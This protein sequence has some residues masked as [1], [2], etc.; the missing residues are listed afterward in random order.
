MQQV[1]FELCR[2]MVKQLDIKDAH[3]DKRTIGGVEGAIAKGTIEGRQ[4]T[5]II[6]PANGQATT[7]VIMATP[8]RQNWADHLVESIRKS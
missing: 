7:T 8:N 2:R 1:A 4:V 6:L 5:V 3:V